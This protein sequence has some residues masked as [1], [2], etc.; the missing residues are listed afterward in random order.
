[1]CFFC[2]NTAETSFLSLL[3]NRSLVQICSLA[4]FVQNPHLKSTYFHN[5]H[6]IPFFASIIHKLS[7]SKPVNLLIQTSHSCIALQISPPFLKC[8]LTTGLAHTH[9][10]NILFHLLPIFSTN[11][12]IFCF[13]LTF[14]ILDKFLTNLINYHHISPMFALLMYG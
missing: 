5:S 11:G 8:I 7:C 12:L 1:M 4:S 14:Q 6:T 13:N 3:H 10:A 2:L 9:N